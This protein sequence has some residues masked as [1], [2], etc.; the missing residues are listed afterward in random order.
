MNKFITIVGTIIVASVVIIFLSISLVQ[1]QRKLDKYKSYLQES[2]ERFHM[3]GIM[4]L[5][6]E[7]EPP[8]EDTYLN[9]TPAAEKR[10]YD[11]FYKK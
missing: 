3:A 5:P 11:K 7:T 9:W 1:T 4:E 8:F 6:I 10:F 2:D